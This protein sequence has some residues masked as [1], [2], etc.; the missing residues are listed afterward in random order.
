MI[1]LPRS[2][3][4]VCIVVV[5]RCSVECGQVGADVV[6]VRDA[7]VGVEDECLLPVV[8]GEVRVA[9]GV[10]DVGETVVGAGLSVAVADLGGQGESGGVLDECLAK[11]SGDV[12]DLTEVVE[13]A[14]FAGRMADLSVKG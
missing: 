3:C 7:E 11:L 2:V 4:S 5:G 10:M 9:G 13:S 6:R 8:A 1:G 14:G 12:P